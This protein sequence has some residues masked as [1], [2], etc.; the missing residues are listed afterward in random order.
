MGL[1]D[2][3]EKKGEFINEL[4]E[5]FN[6]GFYRFQIDGATHK[7]NSP[8]EIQE[9]KLKKSFKHTIDLLIDAVEVID[10][11]RSRLQEALEKAFMIGKREYKL[12]IAGLVKSEDFDEKGVSAEV[13]M[14]PTFEVNSEK[15][16]EAL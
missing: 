13:L 16:S 7:F 1:N 10:D 3:H 8:E 11:E 9:L 4:T 5:L 15:K 12:E 14:E 2:A 6:Q